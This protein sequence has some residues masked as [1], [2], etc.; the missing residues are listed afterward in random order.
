V[1]GSIAINFF[2]FGLV[3]A[4]LFGKSSTAEAAE[5]SSHIVSKL[6]KFTGVFAFL[7]SW[8][9]LNRLAGGVGY[10]PYWTAVMHA[11]CVP[12]QGFCNALLYF[13]A[14]DMFAAF[15]QN[16]AERLLEHQH[17]AVGSSQN[18]EAVLELM[19]EPRFLDVELFVC[20]FNMGEGRAPSDISKLLARDA[21]LYIIGLQECMCLDQ[22]RNAMQTFVSE[23]EAYERYD[24]E[25][26]A[27]NKSLGYHGY[28]ALTMLVKKKY[29][30]DGSFVVSKNAVSQVKQGVNLMVTR[31][32]NKGG[33]GLPCRFFDQSLAFVTCH[34]ASDQHGKTRLHK[35]IE[36]ARQLISNKTGLVLSDDDVGFD[37]PITNHH[38]FVLGGKPR[39]LFLC[40]VPSRCC[41]A[42]LLPECP[43]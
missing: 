3:S 29:V 16:G 26:G 22:M 10:D 28:I 42:S 15:L 14:W 38:T 1:A 20:T 8:G 25:I 7:W 12:L 6:N 24:A 35:R 32:S 36:D 30:D 2:V 33:V 5:A 40:V 21:D 43:L 23:A 11:A 13:D 34:L 17:G 31:A 27:T 37:F 19:P 9:C 18:L 4:E 41:F 39:V